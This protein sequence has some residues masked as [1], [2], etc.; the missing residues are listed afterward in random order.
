MKIKYYCT[1]TNKTR[2]YIV[3]FVDYENRILYEVKPKINT[4]NQ[5]VLD[6]EK[7]AIQWCKE[8]N[9]EFKYITESWFIKN[10]NEE[11][12]KE[13]PEKAKK[14]IKGVLNEKG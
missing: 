1:L 13:I 3:D 6:K 11:I 5:N 4:T 14:R 7:Y 12:L 8:N 10:V 9:Y 2:T